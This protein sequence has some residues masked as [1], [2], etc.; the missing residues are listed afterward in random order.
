MKDSEYIKFTPTKLAQF[1]T[2]Y[3]KARDAKVEVFT[4][5]GRQIVTGFA[6]YLLE[7]V[8]QMLL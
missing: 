6:K 2:A 3:E 4:F 8:E 7:Y 5:E 1:R